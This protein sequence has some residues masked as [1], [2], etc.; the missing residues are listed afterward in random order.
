[1]RGFSGA[2]KGETILHGKNIYN[3]TKTNQMK[4]K[5]GNILSFRILIDSKGNLITELSGLLEKDARKIFNKDDLPIIKK[6][7]REGRIKLEPLH[8]FLENELDS[9]K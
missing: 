5:E 6:I 7:I 4:S 1:M 9:F 2:G 3:I 8:V